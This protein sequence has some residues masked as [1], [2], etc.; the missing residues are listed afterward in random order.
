MLH[1]PCSTLH[2]D[3]SVIYKKVSKGNFSMPKVSMRNLILAILAF[4]MLA[5]GAAFFARGVY[6]A[7]HGT[8]SSELL[9]YGGDDCDLQSRSREFD[10]FANGIYPNKRLQ[11]PGK[12]T[13]RIHTVY[14]PYA[15]PM[16]GFFFGGRSFEASRVTLQALSLLA[17]CLMTYYG[18][19]TLARFG[20]AAL[21][22]GAALP[23]AFTGN[24]VAMTMGQFSIICTGLLVLQF[25]LQT[26]GRPY[27]AGL[28]WAL[29]MI[30][31][32]IAL[33]FGI[34]FLA[35]KQ[36]RGIVFGVSLLTGLTAFALWWCGVSPAEYFAVGLAAEKLKFVSESSHSAGLWISF[37]GL[38]PRSAQFAALASLGVLGA[39]TMILARRTTLP[40]LPGAAVCSALG[41]ALFYH[42]VYDNIMLFPLALA[43]A[44]LYFRKGFSRAEW[45]VF[46]A[47]FLSV[48][49][50]LRFSESIANAEV[51]PL[52]TSLASALL[53][54]VASKKRT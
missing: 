19:T 29:A 44:D 14:P 36:L 48:F 10:E 6:R 2:A 37:L 27:A 41:Y 4:A 3:H 30:K 25:A 21:I 5:S 7:W 53:L 33:P 24:R 8:E 18:A 22:F 45:I 54:A 28:C 11:S 52:A 26:R 42:L 43:V 35:R 50:P 1:A 32:Q 49:L 47:F 17:L 23:W 12:P 38:S 46:G 16:F 15:L 9:T 40:L 13:A 31:P 34:L 51:L 20:P 39:V